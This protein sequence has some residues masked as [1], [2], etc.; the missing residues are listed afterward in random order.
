MGNFLKRHNALLISALWAFMGGSACP[1]VLAAG[2][3]ALA[4][5]AGLDEAA[6]ASLKGAI[7]A[8][9]PRTVPR[10]GEGSRAGAEGEV[11]DFFGISVAIDGGY[12]V[13]GASLDDVGDR[14]N[15]GSA[16]VFERGPAGWTHVAKLVADD[17]TAEDLFGAV[18]IK[19]DT[20]L[21]GAPGK[22]VDGNA[23]RGAAYVF[24]RSGGRWI[25]RARLTASDGRAGDLFGG[26]VS[27]SGDS[28]LVGAISAEVGQNLDQGAAY[29]FVRNGEVWQQQAKLT[30]QDAGERDQFASSV[31]ID[32]D[33][34][35][36]GAD[37]DAVGVNG[38]QGSAYVFTRSG[39]AW[40]QRAKLTASDGT[41]GAGFGRSVAIQGNTALVGAWFPLEFGSPREG[42]AYVFLGSGNA[43]SEQQKLV[44]G[45]PTAVHGFGA[46]VALDGGRALIGARWGNSNRGSAFVFALNNGTWL[47]EAVLTNTS[48]DVGESFGM[49]LALQGDSALIGIPYA[50][51]G[52]NFPQGSVA[53]FETE[54]SNWTRANTLSSGNGSGG[55]LFGW[56]VAVDGATALV[57]APR[58]DLGGS[59]ARGAAY[60]F[61]RAGERWNLRARLAAMD[62]RAGD[63]FG[64]QV[65]VAGDTAVV[66]ARLHS[67]G[68]NIRQ[69]AAYVFVRVGDN[70]QQQTKLTAADGAAHDN[71]GGAVA[72]D[73]DTALCSA[74]RARVGTNATQGAVYVF[75]R[76]GAIWT[77]QARLV[78]VDGEADDQFGSA[79][80]LSDNT[81]LVGALYDDVGTN[82]RQGSAYVFERSG[83]EWSQQAKLTSLD[84]AA[85]DLFGSAVA[86]E[87]DA[88]VVG[89]PLAQV[90]IDSDQGAAYVFSR[91]G[92]GWTQQARL[93]GL[94]DASTPASF[95]SS[96]D[97]S[98]GKV[99]VGAPFTTLGSS[100]EL[101]T[102]YVFSRRSG[103]WAQEAKLI[104]AGGAA[105][106]GFGWSVALAGDIA[107][108]GSSGADGIAPYGNPNEGAAYA[109]LDLDLLFRS[110]FE[111][112]QVVGTTHQFDAHI[113]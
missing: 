96:V 77:Q 53:V 82:T 2:N 95:G 113:R 103:I 21:V 87:G 72:I 23:S 52:G 4:K 30:A 85:H 70:W 26:T 22:R 83:T 3:A 9:L 89:A 38:A 80:A 29:V 66:S 41:A 37:H 75:T 17:A 108:V 28:A 32:G 47:R 43:W 94:V 15:S 19:G 67:V 1:T 48:G 49:S 107:L 39:A 76:E 7:G 5:P 73:G 91:V 61:T 106:D 68:S 20:I 10:L 31:A 11:D 110:G 86:L 33:T 51:V 69:G 65:A 34:A 42:A 88:A 58:D 35:L 40:T 104:A 18:A 60:V 57:G 14:I 44:A 54:G 16:Y 101:G 36:V 24:S 100:I 99:L 92:G 50:R 8:T 64:E 63:R 98:L 71:F 13:I 102:A 112:G 25:Q 45:E 27:L 55:A 93:T 81:A 111:D 105:Y 90:G 109:L 74:P 12:A 59:E 62:G 84:G 78:A 56:S 97:I 6:W 79:V 46:S